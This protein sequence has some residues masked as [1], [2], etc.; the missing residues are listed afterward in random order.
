MLVLAIMDYSPKSIV[1]I[2]KD[3]TLCLLIYLVA[4]RPSIL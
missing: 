2:R 4:F 1:V 3:T